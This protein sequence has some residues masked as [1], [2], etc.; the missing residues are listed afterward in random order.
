[1]FDALV[2]SDT[3]TID[4]NERKLIDLL[5]VSE[6]GGGLEPYFLPINNASD[7]WIMNGLNKMYN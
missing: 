2:L 7:L 5:H 3:E 4:A 1:M 6:D